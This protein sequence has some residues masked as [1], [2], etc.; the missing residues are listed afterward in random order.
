[1]PTKSLSASCNVDRIARRYRRT[2]DVE[3]RNRIVEEY[4]WFAEQCARRFSGRGEP[5]SD[6]TQVARLG[7]VKAADRYEP[8]RPT[9]FESYARPTI[10][11]EIRRHF[12]DRTWALSVSRTS[13]DLRSL[14]LGTSERLEQRLGRPPTDEEIAQRANLDR[15]AVTTTLHANAAYRTTSIDREDGEHGNIADRL[16]ATNLQLPE[17]VERLDV[18]RL[19]QNLDTRSKKVLYWYYFEDR[20]QK[21]IGSELGIGQVQ[22]S[23]LLKSA[24][25]R[26]RSAVRVDAA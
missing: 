22:V 5:L 13:K 20:T 26:L 14:V 3:L 25:R 19:V 12:R 8:D 2:G 6:L 7:L 10:D 24:L 11:G 15:D 9:T 21:D 4:N 1:M 23:R 16:V 17:P 18:V